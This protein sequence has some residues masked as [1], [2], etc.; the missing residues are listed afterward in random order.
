[1]N[2]EEKIYGMQKPIIELKN[3]DVEIKNNT[4][5]KSI[6]WELNTNDHWAI[7]GANGSGK[8]TLLR[9]LAGILWPK[10]GSGIRKYNF[11]GTAQTDAVEA[12][13]KISVVS[14][15]L[16]DS[17]TKLGWGFTAIDIV[18]SGIKKTN[19]PRLDSEPADLIRARS[20]LRTLG[21]AKLGEKSF[22]KL[23]RGQQRRVLIARSLAFKPMVLILD[24]PLA[25]LDKE[26][27]ESLINTIELISSKILT[28]C[29]FHK[30][31]GLPVNTN[32]LL[33]LSDGRIIK[34]EKVNIIK[35]KYGK[36]EKKSLQN[37]DPPS[38]IDKDIMIDIHNASIWFDKSRILSKINWKIYKNQHWQIT[39]P[40]GSG[41]STLIRLLHGQIRPAK[42]GY[43]KFLGFTK[44][45][46]VWSLRK[47]ISWVSPELQANYNYKAN[48]FECIGSGFDSSIG[49]IRKLNDHEIEIIENLMDIFKLE[50]LKLRD[51]K[52][53]SYGQFRR[54]LIARAIVH[55]PKIL[56]LDEPW[57]GLDPENHNLI[58]K[59]LNEIIDSGTQLICAT[60]ID[61]HNENFKLK[62]ELNNGRISN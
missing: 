28:I 36:L 55:K 34:K 26:A 2:K 7:I 11:H 18:L 50:S 37:H 53:L 10:P 14:H 35:N 20:Y 16:Q 60:H 44:P 38:N 5:L 15:E 49:L 59:I 13:K 57:E 56:L 6:N 25:G 42:G 12:L 45:E 27:R 23:S 58:N 21:L 62:I 33:Y 17:Y 4:I 32:N 47:K 39:G 46:N 54:V 48:V 51:V 19:V 41:K 24:E 52:S 40:N 8:S 9:L 31:E 61:S 22:L 3:V 43:I 1:M 30:A 29:S